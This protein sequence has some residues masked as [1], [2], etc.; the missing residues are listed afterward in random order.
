MKFMNVVKTFGSKQDYINEREKMLNEAK[1]LI[2]DAKIDEGNA[3]MK[4]ITEFD[5]DYEAFANAQANMNA[6]AG[7]LPQVDFTNVGANPTAKAGKVTADDMYDTMEYRKA[8]MN[9]VLSGTP[10]MTNSDAN[11][12]TTDVSAVIPT[13]VMNRIVE[14]MENVGTILNMVTRTYYKGGLTIPTSSAKPSASW[15]AEG[16]TSDKQKKTT[17]SV[18]FAYYKLR[19]AISMS[20]ETS[21]ISLPVFESTFVNNVAEAMVKEI[22][23]AIIVGTGSTGNQ[24]KGFLTETVATGQNVDI[25]KTAAIKYADLV[26]ME[27]AVPEAYDIGAKWF[28]RKKTF[29]ENVVGMVDTAGQPVARV[30]VGID[31]KPQPMILGREVVFTDNVAAYAT[32]VASDTIVAAIFNAKDYVLNTSL[33]MTIKKYE[34]NGTDDQV[35]KAIMLLDGKTIDVN[36]LV[37]MTKK[38]A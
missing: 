29:Y 19:C 36:S 30:N 28:M 1:S 14:K 32:T 2:D 24:P 15:V 27:A 13:T 18:T 20:L 26:S 23:K 6:L 33:D 12:K 9:N 17:G 16:V 3:K 38:S 8:F 22:E 5:G 4:D 31:G 10:I 11:T 34:D 35:T 25:A 21:V 7:N 37:T